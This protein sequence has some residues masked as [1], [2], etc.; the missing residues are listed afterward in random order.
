MTGSLGD[1]TEARQSCETEQAQ[2]P[3]CVT[4]LSPEGEINRELT[5]ASRTSAKRRRRRPEGRH[6]V[7]RVR[8]VSGVRGDSPPTMAGSVFDAGAQKAIW[9]LPLDVV[10]KRRVEDRRLPRRVGRDRQSSRISDVAAPL[11]P[12]APRP[13]RRIVQ[14][15]ARYVSG[16]AAD[17]D[18]D[19][20]IVGGVKPRYMTTGL[21]AAPDPS[22][23]TT[24]TGS[25]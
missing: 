21:N 4:V 22:L 18:R 16:G 24:S 17:G 9:T 8:E 19:V 25:P 2:S 23:N 1:T 20:V 6:D 14:P 7:V 12:E 10:I 11:D 5:R 3:W 15:V 13:F